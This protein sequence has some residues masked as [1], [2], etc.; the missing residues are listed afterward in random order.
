MLKDLIKNQEKRGY[1]LPLLDESAL[2]NGKKD[3]MKRRRD[4]FHPSEISGDFCPRSWLLGQRDP[5]LYEK[6]EIP[7]SLQWIFDVGTEVHELVQKR[8]GDTGKLFGLWKCTNG[9]PEGGSMYYGFKPE[10][11][12][13]PGREAWTKWE[14]VEVPVRDDDLNI[15]GHT[16]GIVVLDQGKYIFEFK[17]AN[18]RTF[19][20]LAE[21]MDL[22]KEQASWYLDILSRN[23]WKVEEELEQ[24]QAEGKDVADI[25]R[26]QRQPFKGT[27]IVYMNKDTQVFRE[28]VINQASPLEMPSGV[29]IRGVDVTD[30]DSEDKLSGKKEVLRK[31]LR[32]H[33]EGVLAK[34]H[35]KC[36]SKSSARARKC[37]ARSLCFAEED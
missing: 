23:S 25:L 19:S 9:T 36:I 13:L 15:A 4:V 6:R 26:V 24:M 20:T 33:D 35:E 1:V 21:P 37:F 29:K 17:T 16:D 2:M 12:Q 3:S 22:H 7:A 8:L 14:Y 27:V 5:S 34:R 18:S 10:K 28:F 11:T 30:T 32:Q 31:T